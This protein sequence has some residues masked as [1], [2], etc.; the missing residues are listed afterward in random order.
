MRS[1]SAGGSGPRYLMGRSHA[2]IWRPSFAAS[3]SR[4]TVSAVTDRVGASEASRCSTKCQV[5]VSQ[6]SCFRCSLGGLASSRRGF[7]HRALL[8]PVVLDEMPTKEQ[9]PR[10]MDLGCAAIVSEMHTAF[11][12]SA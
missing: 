7:G 2:E 9:R 5:K 8:E 11:H 3:S 6:L 10:S 1:V 12:C 4:M